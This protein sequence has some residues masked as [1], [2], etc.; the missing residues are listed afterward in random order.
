MKIQAQADGSYEQISQKEAKRI[1]DSGTDAVLLDVRREEEYASGHIPGAV[2]IPN[3]TIEKTADKLLPNRDQLILV[4]CRSG[5]R[6]KQAAEKLC[7]LGYTNV[8]E[9]GGILTSAYG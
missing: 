7:K 8:K 1:M 2:C 9:F 4:Y 6:S 3:E 5:S